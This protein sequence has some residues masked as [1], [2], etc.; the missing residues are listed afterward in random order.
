MSVLLVPALVL[1]TGVAQAETTGADTGTGGTPDPDT[2]LP[3]TSGGVE[4][5]VVVITSPVSGAQL[6]SAPAMVTVDAELS[7]AMTL[8]LMELLVD[9]VVQEEVCETSNVC[10]FAITIEE[11]GAHSLQAQAT[12]DDVVSLSPVVTVSVV[13]EGDSGGPTGGGAT[14]GNATDGN[15]GTGGSSGGDGGC[16]V[17]AAG[18]PTGGLTALG[19]IV[20]VGLGRRRR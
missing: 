5:P 14:D 16:S 20:L 1:A 18:T 7:D 19:L 4:D 8:G 15:A 13:A 2:G 10:M 17:H 3:E 6:G 9:G 11:A 12:V